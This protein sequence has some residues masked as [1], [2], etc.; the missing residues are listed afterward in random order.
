MEGYSCNHFCNGK[1]LSTTYSECVFVALVSRHA[2]RI[3]H[4]VIC[5]LPRS[6][7]FFHINLIIGTVFGKKI[8]EHKMCVLILYTIFF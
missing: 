7:V 1:A 5:G 8:I 4:T 6:T 2:T 3:S